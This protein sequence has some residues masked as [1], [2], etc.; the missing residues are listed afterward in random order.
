M[1]S[2]L[3]SKS[4]T[5]IK[6]L[7]ALSK[8]SKIILFI[9]ISL[10]FSLHMILSVWFKD[11]TWLAA[12]GALLSIFGLLTSFSYSFPLVKV[13]PRDLDETQ[14]GEIYFRGG[15]ALAE[16]I[17]GKKE[18][19]K[20]KESNINSALEK[21]RNISLYFILTVLGTL[22]WAYAGFLNLVLYK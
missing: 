3:S 22:I 20:I 19:D 9:T 1:N 11:F 7:H 16:I 17:E 5:F 14:K 12:F 10:I 18:I 13:N 15:S 4:I 2:P 6:S 21:Y 8:T